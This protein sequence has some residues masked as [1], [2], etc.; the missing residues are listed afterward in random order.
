LKVVR[1]EE[2][3]GAGY[4]KGVRQ[5]F[6][7]VLSPLFLPSSTSSSNSSYM[8]LLLGSIISAVRYFCE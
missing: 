4:R 2:E 8:L 6:K 3:E 5:E 1:V 7:P